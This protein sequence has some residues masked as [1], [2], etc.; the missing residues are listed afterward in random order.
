[1][2]KPNFRECDGD[3]I[4]NWFIKPAMLTLIGYMAGTLFGVFGGIQ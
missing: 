4:I 3:K 2:F 1:M